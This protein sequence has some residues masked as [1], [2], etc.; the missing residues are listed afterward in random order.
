M[1]PT[2]ESAG[3]RRN[4]S[5]VIDRVCRA[6]SCKAVKLPIQY[7]LD[8]ALCRIGEVAAFAEVKVRTHTFGTYP[9]YILS[10][11]K[12]VAAMQYE[13]PCFLIVSFEGDIRY[14]DLKKID[15][16][17][18]IGGRNDRNDPQDVEPVVHIPMGS[19]TKLREENVS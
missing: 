12:K 19:F 13:F 5:G 15:S 2:Y 18:R 8:Y 11:S 6:W 9:T 14:A 16:F 7:K 3:D 17:V 4:E 1:R 10:Y